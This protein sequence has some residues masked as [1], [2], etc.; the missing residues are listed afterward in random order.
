MIVRS[1]QNVPPYDDLGGTHNYTIFGDD[2]DYNEWDT[3]DIYNEM[4]MN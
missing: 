2:S 3:S 1:F 4:P